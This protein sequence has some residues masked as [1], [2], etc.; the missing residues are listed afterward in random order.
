MTRVAQKPLSA[1]PL[2]Q[3]RPAPVHLCHKSRGIKIGKVF[4]Q[5]HPPQRRFGMHFIWQPLGADIQFRLQFFDKP[6]ADI[7]ERSN[8]I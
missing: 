6:L 7:A 1:E 3:R 2:A 5:F 4:R 8:I